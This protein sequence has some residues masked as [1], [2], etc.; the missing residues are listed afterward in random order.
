MSFN[1]DDVKHLGTISIGK[2]DYERVKCETTVFP[3]F[4]GNRWVGQLSKLDDNYSITVFATG[5]EV[6]ER[7]VDT[8]TGVVKLKIRY[9]DGKTAVERVFDCDILTKLGVKELYKYGV[10]FAE[11]DAYKV[12]KYLLKSERIAPINRSY[13]KLGW[14]KDGDIKLFR[15]HSALS[16]EGVYKGLSF[17]GKLDLKPTGDLELWLN[18]VKTEVL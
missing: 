3:Y 11:D 7:L 13:S 9:Y 17:D 14:S 10:R 1:I 15:G 12:V 8:D 4:N 16:A 5:I 6:V 2:E 18:M